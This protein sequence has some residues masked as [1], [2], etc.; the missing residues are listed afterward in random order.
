M[1]N[2]AILIIIPAL[3]SLAGCDNPNKYE[4][5]TDLRYGEAERNI[6]DLCIPKKN[7]HKGLIFYIHGG[8]WIAGDKDGYRDSLKHYACEGYVSAS[9]NYRYANKNDVT[10]FQILEDITNALTL[11][12]STA[13]SYG[14]E[15]DSALLTGPSAGGHL[16]LLYAYA[17]QESAPIKPTCV[18]SYSGPT[19][20][21]DPSYYD[22]NAVSYNGLM[23]IIS[24]VTGESI[25]STNYKE[26]SDLLLS[27]SPI[28]YVNSLTVP[29]VI[30]HGTSDDII[31]Y[32]NAVLLDDALTKASV[33]HE[34]VTYKNAGH[35][36]ETDSKAQKRADKLFESYIEKYLN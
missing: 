1:K 11:V 30:C 5:L 21:T 13:S 10:G 31:P 23:E 3:I 9:L 29:T 33:E 32:S 36:L 26:Y 16:S 24:D 17:C 14:I 15:L 18:V 8:G 7:A 20:F 35:G 19:D 12:K 4:F 27:L 34:F 6:L 25:S 28:Y 22:T 2:K